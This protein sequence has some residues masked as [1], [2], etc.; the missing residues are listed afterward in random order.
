[1]P[2]SGRGYNNIS[3]ASSVAQ[4]N[5]DDIAADV[6]LGYF[7]AGAF[8]DIKNIK[9]ATIKV[10]LLTI[11]NDNRLSTNF[12]AGGDQIQVKLLLDEETIRFSNLTNMWLGSCYISVSAT[13]DVKIKGH[14]VIAEGN[15][16]DIVNEFIR[17]SNL[18]T[19]IYDTMY[20]YLHSAQAEEHQLEIETQIIL[21]LT[22]LTGN[23][24]NEPFGVPE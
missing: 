17:G 22:V 6:T 2:Y 18:E 10:N 13:E 24:K 7:E 9:T 12:L 8:D 5:I 19:P 16:A 4:E 14:T 15:F 23:L 11:R 21:E 20:I 1:M 3:V